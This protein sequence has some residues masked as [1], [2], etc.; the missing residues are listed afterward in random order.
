[1]S[2]GSILNRWIIAIIVAVC[3]ATLARH[4]AAAADTAAA[5]TT[6]PSGPAMVQATATVDKAFDFLKKAQK[7]NNSWQENPSDP[8]GITALVLRA[9]MGD[10]RY[11]ADMPF[12]EKGFDKLLDFQQPNG[13]IYVDSLAEYNTAIAISAL[14]VSKEEEYKAKLGKA[15]AYLESLQWSDKIQGLP[16]TV[17]PTDPNYGG[18]GYGKASR[19]DLSNT[20]FALEALHDAGLK[21]ED[22]AFQAALKFATRCQNLSETNDQKWATDDGGFIYSP[23]KGGSSPAGEYTAPDGRKLFRSYGSM[24][25]AGLKSMIYAGL[26]KDDPRVKAAWAWIAKNYTVD[27]NPGMSFNGPENAKGGIY[28]YYM[29]MARALHAYGEPIIT[30]SQGNKHDWRVELTGKLASLQLPDGSYKGDRKWMEDNSILATSYAALALE[31]V[32]A[33]LKEHPAK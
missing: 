28:Y 7:P 26:T 1:M 11:D 15:V 10:E 23:A 32:R 30:D 4:T 20:Q 6:A 14:A 29:T 18:F 21:P 22:P 5:P 2:R 25:Y 12:L 16:Q 8:P 3:T 31:E 33:D 13:G 19:A 27:E 9:Y 24:T 17:G